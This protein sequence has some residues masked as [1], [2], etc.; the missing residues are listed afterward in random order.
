MR[1]SLPHIIG[2]LAMLVGFWVLSA[3]GGGGGETGPVPAPQPSPP[4]PAVGTFAYL[5]H[6]V[7]ADSGEILIYRVDASGALALA[8]AAPAKPD[9]S[10]VFVHPSKRFVYAVSPGD[11]TISAYAI[12]AST[13]MLVPVPGGEIEVSNF[14]KSMAI[15]PSGKLAYVVRSG[16][17]AVSILDIHPET[18]V[19]SEAGTAPL[20]NG[21]EGIAIDAVGAFLYVGASDGTVSSFEIDTDTGRLNEVNSVPTLAGRSR[22][23]IAPGPFLWATH[24][25]SD[26]LT[27]HGINPGSGA[28]N[29]GT[30]ITVGQG[31]V[32]I[33]IDPIGRFVYVANVDDGTVSA[34]AVTAI[35][36]VTL[37]GTVGSPD[38]STLAVDPS[39]RFLYVTNQAAR[40]VSVYTINQN[41]GALTLLG[42][43][44]P[45]TGNPDGITLVDFQP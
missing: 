26:R 30:P 17:A 38:P 43:P 41:D 19:L 2:P 20:S 35:G 6:G 34:F 3:C 45:T 28:V 18:G 10:S 32:S 31:P 37:S 15:H 33:G 44:L 8:G 1:R 22:L 39:G 11:W 5:A 36:G 4:G 16:I 13:R 9:V 7:D 27:V 12:D 23:A 42:V 40:T 29:A 21:A 25:I 14:P 24:S